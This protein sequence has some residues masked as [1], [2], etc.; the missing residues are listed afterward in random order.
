MRIVV[1]GARLPF[2]AD[3]AADRIAGLIDELRRRGHDVEPVSLPLNPEADLRAQAAAWRLLD[4]RRSNMR[5]IDL[6]IATCFPAYYVRHSNKVAWRRP[7]AVESPLPAQ[8][9]DLDARMLAECTRV[10]AADPPADGAAWDALI[11]Q[12]LG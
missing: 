1:A 6:L 11:E 2:T 8:L 7:S 12:L 5:A 10:V 4:L 9:I 3:T